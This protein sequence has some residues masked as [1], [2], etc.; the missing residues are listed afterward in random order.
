[1][2]IE[3]IHVKL[4]ARLTD[5]E[6]AIYQRVFIMN[7]TDEEAAAALGFRSS[8]KGRA[9]GYKRIRQ[10]KT[11]ALKLTKDLIKEFGLEG[12]CNNE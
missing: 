6:W 12:L 5:S 3:T 11:L 9:I 1:V 7:Q 4:K 2:A 10:V 8:E